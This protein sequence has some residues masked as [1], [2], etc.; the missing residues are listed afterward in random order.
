MNNLIIINAGKFGREVFAWSQNCNEKFILKGF[1]DNRPNILD[2]FNYNI[3][4]LGNVD[5]Y[6]P[7]ENDVFICAI[8]DILLK[9]KLCNIML[10]K[11]AKFINIIHN[12]VILGENVKL[13]NGIII[14]PN[15]VI[16]SDVFIDDFVCINISVC[17]GHDVEI[18]KYCQINPNST[19][20][21]NCFIDEL[22]IIHGN[23]YLIPS[24]SI[25]KNT[26]IGAGSV[27]LKNIEDNVTACGNP[28]RVI[29]RSL[30]KDAHDFSRG[31]NCA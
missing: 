26:T 30:R 29:S 9:R 8:G 7:E 25:G 15:T 27:V 2:D 5:T 23:C 3:K 1:L 10:A 11:N 6:I 21:G 14:C 13:G 31:R 4:I 16:S 12:S 28:A 22:S 19:L 20:S 18:K 17:I 24:I